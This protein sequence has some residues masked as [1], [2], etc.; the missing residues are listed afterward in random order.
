M[1]LCQTIAEMRQQVSHW[2]QKIVGFVP[3]MGN[4]HAGH[5]QLIKQASQT[6]DKVVVSIF[7][8]PLQFSPSEDFATYPRTPQEDLDVL[9]SLGV[10]VVFMPIPQEILPKGKESCTR[11]V[12]SPVAQHLCG[13]SRPGF[14]GGVC[15]ILVKL[16]HIVEPHY[17]FFGE[18]DY[19]QCLVVKHM[20]DD[21]NFPIHIVPVETVREKSGL[22]LS[23][24]NQ[25]LT[26]QQKETASRLYQTLS[27]MKDQ[28]L[29]R[30]RNYHAVEEQGK[31]TLSALGFRVD[32]LTICRADN[33]QS[34][35][36]NTQHMLIAAAVFLEKTRLIDNVQ[37]MLS[38]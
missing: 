19:Q 18:K 15:T 13:L 31:Q 32:Y 38:Q 35:D 17:A 1:I 27:V 2:R 4:L 5:L 23:S 21:L 26:S 9:Q 14:F 10:D 37:V 22:A 20:V 16:F 28:L 30:K 25:Y 12:A 29:T 34:P 3:T 7:V 24:R 36:E 6:V 8:N 11:V 33:L